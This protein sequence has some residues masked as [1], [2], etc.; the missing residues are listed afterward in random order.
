M[1]NALKYTRKLEEVG[2]TKEQAEEN[3]QMVIEMVNENLATKSDFKELDFKF[4]Y[5]ATKEDFRKFEAKV[6]KLEANCATKEELKNL[7]YRLNKRMDAFEVKLV[8]LENRLTI[9]LGI[10][11]GISMGLLSTLMNLM[12]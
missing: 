10:M 1:F 9:K 7:E 6:D 4:S 5:F 12:K 3:V 2:F 11:L 8:S